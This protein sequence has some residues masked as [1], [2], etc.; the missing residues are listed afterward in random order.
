MVGEGVW[1]SHPACPW[2]QPLSPGP[3]TPKGAASPLS[4]GDTAFQRVPLTQQVGY[5]QQMPPGPTLT[6]LKVS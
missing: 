5:F 4:F 6:V 3:P 2:S 1:S